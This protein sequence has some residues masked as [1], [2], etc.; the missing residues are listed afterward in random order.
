MEIHP[1]NKNNNEV[2]LRTAILRKS[3]PKKQYKESK[4]KDNKAKQRSKAQNRRQK[5]R[6]KIKA[7]NRSQEAR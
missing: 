6:Q 1:N 5:S 4:K 7:L 2:I 3:D